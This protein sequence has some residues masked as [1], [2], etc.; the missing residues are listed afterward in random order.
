MKV[1]AKTRFKN[2]LQLEHKLTTTLNNTAPALY[3]ELEYIFSRV[4][5]KTNHANFYTKICFIFFPF[6]VS[7]FKYF[8]P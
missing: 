5:H 7:E 3:Y 6:S 2:F 4:S 8:I 1:S